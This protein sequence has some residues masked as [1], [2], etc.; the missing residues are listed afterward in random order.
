MGKVILLIIIAAAIYAFT[1]PQIIGPR[2]DNFKYQTYSLFNQEKTVK[3]VH[4]SDRAVEQQRRE[5]LG[6]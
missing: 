1:N 4:N 3:A 2:L 5:L 6:Q